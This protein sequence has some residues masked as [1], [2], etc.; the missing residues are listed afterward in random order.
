MENIIVISDGKFQS[1]FTFF[2][3]NFFQGQL[4]KIYYICYI[5]TVVNILACIAVTK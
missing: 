5:S 1:L 3:V 2:P 4:C